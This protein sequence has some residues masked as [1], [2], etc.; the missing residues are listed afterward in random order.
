M[1]IGFFGLFSAC[2]RSGNNQNEGNKA[3]SGNRVEIKW[4]GQWFG[5]GKKENLVREI[6]CDFSFQNQGYSVKLDFPHEVLKMDINSDVYNAYARAIADMVTKN[7][8]PYDLMLCDSYLYNTVANLIG[9]QH[10]GDKYLMDFRN[11]PWFIEAHEPSIF[12]AGN[13]SQAFGGL[14]PGAYIEGIWDVL[15][16]SDSVEQKVGIKAKRLDMT[17][18][19]FI[20]YAKA[21]Y[22]Y[23]QSHSQKITFLFLPRASTLLNQMAM[24]VLG[25]DSA[26][27]K[28]EGLAVIEQ[29][30]KA[31]EKIAPYHPLDK[32]FKEVNDKDLFEDK[33]FFTYNPSWISL[34][35]ESRYHDLEKSM[36]PCEIPS[37]GNN[38]ATCYSGMYNAIFV[39]P[40]NA[41]NKD[42]AIK[43][44]KF[45]SSSETAEK[46]VKYSKCPTGLKHKE[47]YSD[48]ANSEINKFSQ[49]IKAKYNNTLKEV[50]LAKALFHSNKQMEFYELQIMRGEITSETAMRKVKEQLAK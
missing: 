36:H 13:K 32:Y 17:L 35:W 16:V 43:L 8:W 1:L 23:N 22:D 12:A 41:K 27:S 37:I 14:M 18:D 48:L 29:V 20:S 24:S 5:E 26:S 45:I 31:M 9:D 4:M 42:G 21:V 50:N 11:E 30:Y 38:K 19:D 40:K 33:T 6:A 15:Y 46:W 7:N 10:W 3:S 25:K 2:K 49:H 39:V 34:I 44:M 47:V 28:Q